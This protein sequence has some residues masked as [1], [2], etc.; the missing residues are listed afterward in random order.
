VVVLSKWRESTSPA[1]FI[2]TAG[3]VG[4]VEH[5]S[6]A[7]GRPDRTPEGSEWPEVSEKNMTRTRERRVGAVA[8]PPNALRLRAAPFFFPTI[9]RYIGR[10]IDYGITVS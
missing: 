3:P 5:S 2:S 6:T 4:K 10:R 7:P 8:R 9:R 1:Y